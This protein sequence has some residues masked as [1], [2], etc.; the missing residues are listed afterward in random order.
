MM[1][2]PVLPIIYNP[3]MSL[4]IRPYLLS[5]MLNVIIR[6]DFEFEKRQAGCFSIVFCTFI[7][8]IHEDN[9]FVSHAA[10]FSI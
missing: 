7:A 6:L 1:L 3:E 8:Q 2:Q 4:L 10:S 9:T 5:K